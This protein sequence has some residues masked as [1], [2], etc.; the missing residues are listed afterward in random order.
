SSRSADPASRAQTLDHTP[1]DRSASDPDRSPLNLYG[2][3][4]AVQLVQFLR[5]EQKFNSLD[6]LKAQIATDCTI[7]RA[8]L[9]ANLTTP[10]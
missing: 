9:R 3:T 6:D 4:L 7:A 5:S 1:T 10:T 2:Q 8:L